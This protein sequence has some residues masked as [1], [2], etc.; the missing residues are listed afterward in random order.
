M[1]R[2]STSPSVYI[3]RLDT[4]TTSTVGFVRARTD[5]GLIGLGQFPP[6]DPGILATVFHKHVA[7]QALGRA[8]DERGEI[9]TTV[10][11]AH[12][13]TSGYTSRALAGLDTALWDLAG[14]QRAQPVHELLGGSSTVQA[15]AS[16]MRR[17]TTPREEA[18]RLQQLR[19]AQGFDAVKLRIG[20]QGAIGDDTDQWPGRTEELVPVVRSQLGDATDIY[21]DANCAFTP[22]RAIEIGRNVLEPNDVAMFEEPCPYWKLDWTA[23]VTDALDVPVAGG[24]LVNDPERWTRMLDRPAVDIVQPDICFGGGFT[25]AKDI[26]ERAL[27]RGIRCV[28]HAATHSMNLV[29][30]AQLIAGLGLDAYLEYSVDNEYIAEVMGKNPGWDNAL[31]SP[32]IEISDGV[33]TLPADPGWGVTMASDMRSRAERHVSRSD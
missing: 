1:T 23:D 16:S 8:V 27:D 18:D 25:R 12:R 14:K 32:N 11:D 9:V 7:P 15:Y 19:D 5:T 4:Y 26:T 24:E 30:T 28:P 31:Y 6:R 13:A 20:E 2:R 33:I 29:F 10:L 17:S 21:V 3:E 22:E